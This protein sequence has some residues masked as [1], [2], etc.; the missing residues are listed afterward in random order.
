MATIPNKSEPL[1]ED[2]IWTYEDYLNLPSDGK[3]YEIIGGGLVMS[4]A[5]SPK[6]QKISRNLALYIWN[7]VRKNKLGEVYYAPI[8][9][10]LDRL[11]VVQ[12]D[13]VYVA[14]KRCE[15]IKE[16]GIF[17]VPD[18]I[19]EILSPHNAEVD[20]KKKKQ[21]YEHFAV[22]EYWIVNPEIKKVEVYIM[23]GG[24]YKH[25]GTYLE[26]DSLESRQIEGL[27]V[28]L[29]EVFDD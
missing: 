8:D 13:L 12:P 22:R 15:I 7:Y 27:K 3:I 10:I 6:H 1:Y 20:I 24:G 19:V 25:Q 9:L 18:L 21:L 4:P 16:N 26:Q 17:G 29:S 14:R 11:N 5:P 28:P 2:D 23:Q